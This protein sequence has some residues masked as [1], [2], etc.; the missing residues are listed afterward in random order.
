MTHSRFLATLFA[1]AAVCGAGL[2]AA[3][4]AGIYMIDVG[5]GNAVLLV[6]PS[7]ETMLMDTGAR[8]AADR[9]I[10]FMRDIGVKQLDYLLISHFEEDHMGAATALAEKI[11]I[12]A[13]VD[14]GENV[15]YGK[16]L[17]WWKQRRAPWIRPDGGQRIDATYDAYR[18]VRAKA[19][20]IAVKCGDRIPIQGVDAVVVSSGGQV[21][22]KPLPGAGAPNSACAGVERRAEDDAEDG[23]SVGVLISYGKFR[24]VNL[25]DLTWNNAN[26]LFCPRNLLGPVDAYVVTHHAQSLP[27]DLGGYYR[28]LS[29][30][31]PS[32]LNGLRPRVA[33]LTLGS[34]G[35]K[36][37]TSEAIDTVR[38]SPGL[39]DL[40]QTQK[41]VAGG[42]QGHNSA[43]DFIANIGGK[44]DRT[45]YIK[46]SA[47][48]D[49]SFT[50]TNSRNGFS[51]TYPA[52]K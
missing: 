31:P 3:P 20:H 40:W 47:N 30:C 11:P 21:L 19:R 29:C 16:S 2:P 43:D 14:H 8:F 12:R 48:R 32:E 25:G 17:E 13:F 18:Q 33:L 42:E 34:Q 50:A 6:S 45:G 35:H 41:I 4:A 1:L 27:R 39:E 23:Q 36:L 26:A 5:Q 24:A 46:L 28:G 9:V 7:G 37:G 49:G 10:G 22:T 15:T 51:K 44:S 38:K 52:R